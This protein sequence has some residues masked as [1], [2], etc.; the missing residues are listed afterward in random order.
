MYT[1]VRKNA[2]KKIAA[3]LNDAKAIILTTS[4]S[5]VDD[6]YDSSHRYADAQEVMAWL[7]DDY[8]YPDAKLYID[9]KGTFHVGG[10]YSFCD[11]FK[12]VMTD[13]ELAEHQTWYNL[14]PLGNA[15]EPAAPAE[16]LP[17]N[18]VSLCDY[19]NQKAS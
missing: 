10:P 3:L 19:R 4:K 6:S 17:A 7:S 2:H 1:T 5:R 8:N 16:P 18:V 14:P 9:D 12:A 11:Q 15:Q 13:D